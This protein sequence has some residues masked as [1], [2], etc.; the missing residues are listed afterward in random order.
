MR[1]SVAAAV[2]GGGLRVRMGGGYG[3]GKE[4]GAGVDQGQAGLDCNCSRVLLRSCEFNYKR[5]CNRPLLS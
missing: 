2:K 4:E 3:L 5:K 1:Q